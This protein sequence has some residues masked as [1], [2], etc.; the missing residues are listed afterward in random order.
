MPSCGCRSIG[1][2]F[3]ELV[4]VLDSE[5]PPIDYD[6]DDALEEYPKPDGPG[7]ENPF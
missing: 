2:I 1:D 4:D 7:Y 5:F 3:D 6:L